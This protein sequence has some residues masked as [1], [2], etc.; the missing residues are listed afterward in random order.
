M[1]IRAI[2][3]NGIN[4]HLFGNNREL[5][6]GHPNVSLHG[7]V[8]EEKFTRVCSKAKITLGY[9]AVNDIYFMPLGVVHL[10]VWPVERFI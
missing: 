5:F 6:E 3:D 4:I 10:I 9:N 8:V 2:A 7:F 1:L